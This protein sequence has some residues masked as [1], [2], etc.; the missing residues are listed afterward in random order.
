MLI[1]CSSCQA[2][3][4]VPDNAAGKKGKCPKCGAVMLI[5][6]AEA[7]PEVPPEVPPV[8]AAP[9][10][11]PPPAPAPAL[12][13]L[14]PRA[15]EA[16]SET[17]SSGPPPIPT[18]S[19]R[20]RDEDEEDEE[21]RPSRRRRD[22]DA[23]E[24][25]DEPR[26]RGDLDIQ[27]PRKESRGLSLTSM[28]LGIIAFGVALVSVLGGFVFGAVLLAAFACPCG[29]LGAPLGYGG[30]ALSGVLSLV[31]IP[32]GLFGLGKGGR[33]MAITGI[34]LSVVTLLLCLVVLLLTLLGFGG[35]LV[36]GAN[37]Q[38]QQPPPRPPF[39]KGF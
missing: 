33:G 24:E 39:R 32:L 30:I 6:A 28:I 14:F 8:A 1:A 19:R 5:P 16:V 9:A 25:D 36:I 3:I 20:D 10:P 21:D 17:P 23:G 27:R 4:K 35:L 7:A 29:C 2:K 37:A 13:D 18:R 38:P 34:S 22:D 15:E 26:R 11:P 12:P 31:A